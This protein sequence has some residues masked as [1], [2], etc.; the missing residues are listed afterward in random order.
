VGFVVLDTDVAS[1]LQK[2][3]RP[4]DLIARH[5]TGNRMATTFVTEGELEKW[6]ERRSWGPR[7]RDEFH[8]WTRRLYVLPYDQAVAR[9]WGGL[10]A[11]AEVRGRPRPVKDTWIAACCLVADLPL[12]TLKRNRLPRLR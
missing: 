11:R 8:T 5:L 9:L 4:A 1:Q 6:A 12:L 10:A 2:E 7:R 3:R